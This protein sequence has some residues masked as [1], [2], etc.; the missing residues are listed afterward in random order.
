[1]NKGQEP[2]LI[3]VV[4]DN[5][6]QAEYLRYILEKNG[7]KVIVAANGFEALGIL[8]ESVPDLVLTDVIMPE[9]DGYELCARI[10][11]NERT[12]NIPVILVTHL[13]DPNDVIKGLESG[14]DNFIIKP[15]DPQ[16]ISSR[17]ESTILSKGQNDPDGIPSALC[18]SFSHNVHTITAS[19]IQILNI[20]LSTY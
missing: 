18:V 19:R 7:Y 8:K 2:V 17:L 11:G 3:L 12:R 14:A 4:E 20:L 16:F 10:K 5:R 9:I 13:Y 1:M 15:Y 6:T